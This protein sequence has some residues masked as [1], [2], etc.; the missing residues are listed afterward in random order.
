M[1]IRPA[2]RDDLAAVVSVMNAVDIA[3]LGEPDTTEDDIASGWDESVFDVT[4]DAFVAEADGQIIGYGELYERE[5]ATFDTDVY[6]H[7]D[8]PDAVVAA[9]LDA[10]LDRATTRAGPGSRL[11]TWVPVGDRS[12]SAYAAAGFEPARMFVRMRHEQD[13]V[14]APEVPAGIVVRPFEPDQEAQ[15]VHQVLVAAFAGHVRPMTPSFERFRE[16]HLEHPDF[17]PE[18]WLVAESDGQLVGAIT[19][20]D[21]GDIGFIRHV[22][23]R[24]GHRG[25]GIGAAL[26]LTALQRL[27]DRGQQ[28]VDLGVD[29]EDDVGAATLYER[30]GFATL[31]QLQLVERGL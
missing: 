23:V 26:V 6:A 18:L 16:Q 14:A 9:L 3:T 4:A 22:G 2:R 29:V 8:A 12:A 30:L 7:P 5:E 10:V 1:R 13:A 27:A 31:Q 19:A 21:H 20:F 15:L 24:S 17:K 25:R 11:G 28:R